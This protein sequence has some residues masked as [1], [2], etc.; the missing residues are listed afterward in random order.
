MKLRKGA[1]SFLFFICLL[2]S[3]L[4]VTGWFSSTSSF[5]AEDVNSRSLYYQGE[6]LSERGY[7]LNGSPYVPVSVIQRYGD[8][9]GITFDTAAKKMQI[10]LAKQSILMADDITTNFVKTY[11]GTVYIPLREIDGTLYCPLNTA[12]QLV[13]LSPSLSANAIRMFSY[14]GTETIARIN[15]DGVSL[16][17]SLT[18]K[19]RQITI[20]LTKGEMVTVESETDSYFKI[21]TQSGT[22][23]YV[24][25]PSLTIAD[26]DLAEIDFYAPKKEKN[27]PS[28]EKINIVWQYVGAVTPPAP[29]QKHAGIDVLAPTWFDLIVDGDG[30]IENNGDLAYTANA[31]NKGY[32]VWATITNNMSTKGSTAFTTKVL[33]NSALLNRSVA[34]YLFYACLYDADGI[35]IDYEQVVDSDAAGLTAFTALLRNYTE[36]QGLV[37]SIDTLIPKPW[38]IEYDRAALSRYVDYLAVMTYDEHYSTSPV[39]GSVASLPWVEEAIVNTLKEVPEE[40][41]LLGVPM[42]TRVWVVDSNGKV[43]RN[44]S[45]SMPYV[46][47]L[48][49]EK[50]LTP[51]WLEKEK[52]NFVSYANGAY[53]DK[54]WVEDARS[55][56][57]R[58]DLVRKY[59]LAGSAC[60][61]FSQASPE[62]WDVFSAMLKNGRPM[63]DYQ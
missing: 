35:N 28:G 29:E 12:E 2:V 51:I 41:I 24:M 56:A 59:D 57:N 47:T 15:S 54:I 36:R 46:Q 63:S 44:P 9:E 39:A 13:K 61:Q 8:L 52:Q 1:F 23:G 19:N 22:T 4:A 53:T 60:W 27:L 17:S 55:I 21:S 38:T 58:L 40:K 31:H 10:D 16:T 30:N 50:N 42:Y 34:Q 43:I 5:G 49:A 62:I 11:G 37:L 7:D 18:E 33:S 6:L 32:K 48:I 20:P 25:K 45:A 26:V 3:V 14:S